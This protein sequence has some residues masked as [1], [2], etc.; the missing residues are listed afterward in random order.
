[1]KALET[2]LIDV[3]IPF[4]H[5]NEKICEFKVLGLTKLTMWIQP[6]IVSDN[7]SGKTFY[8]QAFPQ[9]CI[10]GEHSFPNLEFAQKI[11][12]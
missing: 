2:A 6:F 11:L 12:F 5:I 4:L 7:S 9:T 1:L 3:L 8:H 10:H